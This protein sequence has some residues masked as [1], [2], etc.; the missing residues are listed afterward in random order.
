MPII[1][2]P[3]TIASSTQTPTG[4][5]L[6]KIW[7]KSHFKGSDKYILWT[8]WFDLPQ[9]QLAE[10][11]TVII[12]GRMSTKNGSYM[13]DGEQKNVVEHHLNDPR[14]IQHRATE[15]TPAAATFLAD[16]VPF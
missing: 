13:K 10:H 7:E 5:G 16:E 9:A 1:Q 4:K 8:C 15:P 6:V 11:D 14:I 2:V 3:G 12:E